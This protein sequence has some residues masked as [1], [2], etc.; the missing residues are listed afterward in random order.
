[1]RGEKPLQSLRGKE[2]LQSVRGEKSLQPV[3]GKEKVTD[4]V[5]RRRPPGRRFGL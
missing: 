4:S 2:S 1:L 5:Q 3:R